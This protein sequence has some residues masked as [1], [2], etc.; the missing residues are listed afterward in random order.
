MSQ[1]RRHH[2]QFVKDV[3][4]YVEKNPS[5]LHPVLQKFKDEVQND[6]RL[7]MLFQAMLEEVSRLPTIQFILVLTDL[8]QVPDNKKYL[9][10]PTH[11]MPQVRDFDKYV[12]VINYVIQSGPKWT[13]AGNQA[14]LVG[15]PLNALMDWGMGTRAGFAVFQDP[16]IN[17]LVGGS[18]VRAHIAAEGDSGCMGRVLGFAQVSRDPG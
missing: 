7:R 15:V 1:D 11:Q 17:S 8:N 4:V 6:T 10:D 16:K 5:E 18:M 9:T 12:A 2:Q 13:H 14:G 3:M